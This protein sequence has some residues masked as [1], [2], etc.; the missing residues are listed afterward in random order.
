MQEIRSGR[1]RPRSSSCGSSIE[2]TLTR[3]ASA[4][5]VRQPPSSRCANGTF[6]GATTLIDHFARLP[7]RKT[8][9]LIDDRC[10]GSIIRRVHNF[11]KDAYVLAGPGRSGAVVAGRR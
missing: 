4:A 1:V 9:A 10:P 3:K 6:S 5:E 11:G 8:L 2:S 7:L